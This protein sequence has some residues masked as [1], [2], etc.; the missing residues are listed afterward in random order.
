MCCLDHCEIQK[1]NLNCSVNR[2]LEFNLLGLGLLKWPHTHMHT[3]K[4][5]HKSLKIWHIMYT[6]NSKN[7]QW[8]VIGLNISCNCRWGL[9]CINCSKQNY[10]KE[11]LPG[12]STCTVWR[13]LPQSHISVHYQNLVL[14]CASKASDICTSNP[15]LPS[16]ITAPTPTQICHVHVYTGLLAETSSICQR[17]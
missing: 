14:T 13:L 17:Q 9:K 11:L 3:H 8:H 4:K 6:L 16:P 7:A 12:C 5:K 1:M 10:L 15:H 2:D